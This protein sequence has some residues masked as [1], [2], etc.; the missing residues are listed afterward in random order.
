MQARLFYRSRH[1]GPMESLPDRQEAAEH[2]E[3]SARQW[4][5]SFSDDGRK[6]AEELDALKK[7]QVFS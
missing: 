5:N 7:A 6:S 2:Y 4:L 1:P 3:S